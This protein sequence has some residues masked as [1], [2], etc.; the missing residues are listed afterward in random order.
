MARMAAP[1]K[2]RV[3]SIDAFRGFT[4]VCMISGSFGLL[5]YLDHPVLGAVAEQFRHAEWHGMTAWDLVQPFFMFIVGA[6]MPISFARR[7]ASGETWAQSFGHVLRRCALLIGFGLLARSIQA[8]RPVLDLINV[9]AQLAFTYF[10]A[11]LLLR[12]GWRV[13]GAAAMGL[14]ALH[15]AFYQFASAPGV[16]GPWV[17]NANIGWYLDRAILGKNWGGSYATINCLSSA[18]NTIFGVM[19]GA[20]LTGSLPAARKARILVLTGVAAIAAGLA[21]DPV[22]PI[23]K[24]IWTASF[25]LYSLGFTLLA[26]LFFYW[27]CDVMG[28]RT[29]A[30]VFVVVGSNSIFI[31]LLHEILNRWLTHTGLVFTGWAVELWGPAGN[32]LNTWLVLSFQIWLC[33]WLYRRKIFFKI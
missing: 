9:L 14:L 16:E 21:L 15:W 24:K 11:F 3:Y 30:R 32:V 6:V 18:A 5:F 23:I 8:D 4:M 25:A 33:F 12:A 2:E 13:Q 10:V 26:L 31:Y 7:W 28:K 27:V 29:W 1:E 19:A 22:I 17:R 20:L